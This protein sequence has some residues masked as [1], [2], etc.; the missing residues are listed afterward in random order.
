MAMTIV[1]ERGWRRF[2]PGDRWTTHD[3]VCTTLIRRNIAVEAAD[4]LLETASMAMGGARE[5]KRA[6]RTKRKR[7]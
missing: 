4:D 3:G 7:G 2:K 1:F 6:R 5:T